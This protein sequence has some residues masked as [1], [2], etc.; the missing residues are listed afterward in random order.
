[1]IFAWPDLEHMHRRRTAHAR[2][3]LIQRLVRHQ[4]STG[5]TVVVVF[6]GKGG[7]T[8]VDAEETRLQVF[9]SKSGQ[10]AD[11][12]IERLVAKYSGSHEI[13]VA[14]DDHLEQTTVETFGGRWMSSRQLLLEMQNAEKDLATRLQ[15]LRQGK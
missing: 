14:T 8:S 4:D 7:R 12:V 11:S 15:R 1:M 13:T 2:E 10:S 5:I 6:D 3:E 9:Y